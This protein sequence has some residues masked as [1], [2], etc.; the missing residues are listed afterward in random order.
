MDPYTDAGNPSLPTNT[1]T[2]KLYINLGEIAE[3]V[4]KDGR[5]QYENGI[6]AVG[7]TLPV[8]PTIWGKVPASQSLIY[9]FDTDANN[10]A[11]Q[12]VG[13]DGLTDAEELAKF[14]DYAGQPDPSG[15][16]FQY[17]LQATGGIFDRYKNYN[18]LQGNS[19]VDV[20]DT[21]RGS[22]TVPDVEDI[23]RDNTM[24]TINGYYEYGIDV[25]NSGAFTVGQNYV[26]DI[27]STS[28]NVNGTNKPTRW[29]Q[30]KI[31]ITNPTSTVGGISDFRSIRF[32][33]MFLT[34]FNDQVTL[35]FGALAS[36]SKF[37][38]VS[39]G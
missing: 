1:N 30:F 26:T 12:D 14:P 18:N 13:F 33:R 9:A 10:R 37:I 4:L 3:D 22:T 15:D 27:V 34:G 28:P 20:T 32:M 21:N 17:F 38:T 25:N 35:R 5:K 11:V 16:N 24:N 23:N 7:S 29:I 2:G 8:A 36:I 19:P 6:P 39:Y 31:P